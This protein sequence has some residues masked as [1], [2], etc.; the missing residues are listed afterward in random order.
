MQLKVKTFL[1]KKIYITQIVI[2]AS[3]YSILGASTFSAIDSF[4]EAI[5]SLFVA[6]SIPSKEQITG[7][8]CSKK[9]SFIF[10]CE[11]LLTNEYHVKIHK[12][13]ITC[14]D[15]HLAKLLRENI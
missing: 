15:L 3:N 12:H 14:N 2:P 11:G 4:A 9:H 8:V 6:N 13:S 10:K 5:R 1:Q 7:S